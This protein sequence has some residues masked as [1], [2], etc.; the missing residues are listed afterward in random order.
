METRYK[1]RFI[2][3]INQQEELAILTSLINRGG[4][5]WLQGVLKSIDFVGRTKIVD[6]FRE[7]SRYMW[8]SNG[9][10]Q[11]PTVPGRTQADR[12]ASTMKLLQT[13]PIDVWLNMFVN[14][15]SLQESS[16]GIK[17]GLEDINNRSV[18]NFKYNIEVV[19]N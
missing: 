12:D 13:R 15:H 17:E 11:S 18:H 1:I 7:G 3:Q 9:Y 19:I 14:E 5:G 16:W 2:T 8:T 6:S 10:Q 4:T